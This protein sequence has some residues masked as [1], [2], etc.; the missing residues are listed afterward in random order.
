MNNSQSGHAMPPH[1]KTCEKTAWEHD[2]R[3]ANSLTFYRELSKS[4]REAR[5][6]GAGSTHASR[7]VEIPAGL[8]SGRPDDSL[9]G[10]QTRGP[11]IR[12]CPG[13]DPAPG[14]DPRLAERRDRG[15]RVALKLFVTS[16]LAKRLRCKRRWCR[17]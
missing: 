13:L 9:S 11:R 3:S 17:R 10:E 15:V 16:S 5:D 7:S 1:F 14:A 2:D 12:A 4:K 8:A 6:P